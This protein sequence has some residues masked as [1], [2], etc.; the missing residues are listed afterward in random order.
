[1]HA[2]LPKKHGGSGIDAGRT[3]RCSRPWNLIY[4]E[5]QAQPLNFYNGVRSATRLDRYKS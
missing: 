1:M 2:G 5:C 4:V 3:I